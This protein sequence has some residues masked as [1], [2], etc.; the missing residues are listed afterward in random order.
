MLAY[1]VQTQSVM[2]TH[3][4]RGP[5]AHVL[6][7]HSGVYVLRVLFYLFMLLLLVHGLLCSYLC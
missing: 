4:K 3:T 6:H 7:A 5:T 1:Q 2:G